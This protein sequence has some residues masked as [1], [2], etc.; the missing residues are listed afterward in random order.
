[1]FK[2]DY[3]KE[4]ENIS[5]SEKFKTDTVSL[6]YAKQEEINSA[7]TIKFTPKKYVKIAAAVAIMIFSLTAYSLTENE[8]FIT[9]DSTENQKYEYLLDYK[10]ADTDSL[11][12]DE[13][14]NAAMM[15]VYTVNDARPL[16]A[17]PEAEKKKTKVVFNTDFSNGMGFEGLMYY[18]ISQLKT[19][20]PFNISVAFDSLPVYTFSPMKSEDIKYEFDKILSFSG[21]T[22]DDI[23]SVKYQWVEFSWFDGKKVIMDT[24]DSNTSDKPSANAQLYNVKVE[25]TDGIVEIWPQRSEINLNLYGTPSDNAYFGRYIAENYTDLLGENLGYF[26]Y[27]DYNIYGE[28][29]DSPA[30]LYTTSENYAESIFYHSAGSIIAWN[31]DS[32]WQSE[33]DKGENIQLQ[34]KADCAYTQTCVLDAISWQEALSMFYNGDYIST[35]YEPVTENTVVSKIELVYKEPSYYPPA[36]YKAGYALPFYKFYVE[37]PSYSQ[38][39]DNGTLKTYGVYYIC[40]IHPDYVEYVDEYVKFN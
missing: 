4:I 40:A 29:N 34:Y 3:R 32:M 27:G 36:D 23:V 39:T 38:K 15:R 7:K 6:M 1:M 21:M 13:Q 19:N 22:E 10:D 26:T 28:K 17:V 12:Y 14:E 30:Y 8:K 9:A 33:N 25:L 11:P 2:D 18:D 5:A 37:L 31:P 24:I 20:N 35:V 16:E